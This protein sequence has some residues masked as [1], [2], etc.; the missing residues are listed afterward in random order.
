MMKG[1]SAEM[2]NIDNLKEFFYKGAN[3]I[4]VPIVGVEEKD[5]LDSARQILNYPAEVVEWRI[6]TY[7]QYKDIDKVI[8]LANEI[9]N[10]LN[11]PVLGTFRTHKEGGESYIE[12]SDYCKMLSKLIIDTDIDMIDVE[13]FFLEEG[14]LRTLIGLAHENNVLVIGSNHDF[15]KTPDTEEI[16]DRLKNMYVVGM[17][18]SKIAVMPNSKMD[19]IRLLEATCR[20]NEEYSDIRTITMSMSDIGS[21]SRVIG[22]EFGNVMTFG[23]AKL[24]SAPGQIDSNRLRNILDII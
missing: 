20:I 17:D 13:Y 14:E 4:C 7:A 19:V 23:T 22:G 3:R 16:Y 1:K 8:N 6:D 5:I 10:I 24:A 2:K 11:M 18:I 21:I 9:K 15:D 12:P